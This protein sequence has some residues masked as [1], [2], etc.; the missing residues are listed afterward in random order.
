MP[1]PSIFEDNPDDVEKPESGVQHTTLGLA[2]A[3][4][5]IRVLDAL[6]P[7]EMQLHDTKSI[8]LSFLH[9]SI[10]KGDPHSQL[11]AF[12]LHV[13]R[14]KA[15]PT[16]GRPSWPDHAA[17]RYSEPGSRQRRF[18]THTSTPAQTSLSTARSIEIPDLGSLPPL[19]ITHSD[20]KPP[21]LCRISLTHHMEICATEGGLV[22]KGGDS[23]RSRPFEDKNTTTLLSRISVHGRC[24]PSRV[25]AVTRLM[26]L[27]TSCSSLPR[28]LTRGGRAA[29]RLKKLTP[30]PASADF[31]IQPWSTSICS[32]H[33]SCVFSA[34]SCD[35]LL[36]SIDLGAHE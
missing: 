17:R 11:Y 10:Q 16:M 24:S 25:A 33:G 36:I 9:D 6:G 3:P 2:G 34:H 19:S 26:W 28:W 15:N 22:K 14:R 13:S 31:S 32:F 27:Q 12:H 20:G 18:G 1:R 35:I 23:V 30:P 5:P 29:G 4:T 8:D 21:G 7:P